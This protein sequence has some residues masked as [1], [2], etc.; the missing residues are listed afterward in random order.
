M[1]LVG[2]RVRPIQSG[3]RS[4]VDE[5]KPR[6]LGTV[7]LEK[8]GCDY[9]SA[10]TL[11][12]HE[13][14]SL[15]RVLWSREQVGMLQRVGYGFDFGMRLGEILGN[16]PAFYRTFRYGVAQGL[17]PSFFDALRRNLRQKRN[18]RFG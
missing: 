8:L 4:C 13:N 3:G 5:D 14:A 16:V 17:Y 2:F 7:C 6:L 12:S 18:R 11:G 15:G 1:L 10:P 9:C